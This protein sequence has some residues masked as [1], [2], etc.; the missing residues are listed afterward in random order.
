MHESNKNILLNYIVGYNFSERICLQLFAHH[1]HSY[2][3]VK[4]STI[5]ISKAVNTNKTT[6]KD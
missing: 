6:E 5:L 4:Y 1:D 2:D 3:E